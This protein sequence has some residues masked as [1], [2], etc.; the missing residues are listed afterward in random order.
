MIS[1]VYIEVVKIVQEKRKDQDISQYVDR[2]MEV[3]L[4]I[5]RML[6][7]EFFVVGSDIED[8]ELVKNYTNNRE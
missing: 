4:V 8:G 6:E 5:E 7:M 2:M 3:K 1:G